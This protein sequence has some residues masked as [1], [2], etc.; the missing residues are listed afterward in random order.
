MI[1]I[2][3]IILYYT[4]ERLFIDQLVTVNSNFI[5][6]AGITF[7]IGIVINTFRL[8]LLHNVEKKS[9]TY[10]RLL[11]INFIGLFF[12]IFLPG[13]TSGDFVRGYY[14]VKSTGQIES[15]VSTILIWRIIGLINMFLIASL[16]SI[17]SYPL[18]KNPFI[19]VIIIG[20]S[21]FFLILL[22]VLSNTKVANMEEKRF[23]GKNKKVLALKDFIKKV[24]RCLISYKNEKRL[25]L[26]NVVI[27]FISNLFIIITW[28]LIAK[29][30]SADISVI[31]FLLFIPM[32]SILQAIPISF[33]GI[34]IREA[35]AIF[36]FGSIGIKM[37]IIFTISLLFSGLS[38]LIA[39]IGG[40]IY[41]FYKQEIGIVA[42]R[43]FV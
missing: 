35:S 33:N 36:L 42:K 19:L 14:L 4:D 40:I 43:Y 29:S 5:F 6:G 34:G 17:V 9:V 22:K 1:L 23:K 16:S 10:S 8:Q 27:S 13:R 31:I 41:I 15:T 25:L 24:V 38:I 32:V 21:C 39:L 7:V 20:S 18:L 12:S 30:I 37:E 2:L 28:V 3:L 11:K 26:E